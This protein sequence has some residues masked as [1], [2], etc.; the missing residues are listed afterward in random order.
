MVNAKLVYGIT[1]TLDDIREFKSEKIHDAL[2]EFIES[3]PNTEEE[4]KGDPYIDAIDDGDWELLGI[5]NKH[6]KL[7][8]QHNGACCNIGGNSG[9]DEKYFVGWESNAEIP[10]LAGSHVIEMITTA[11]KRK[12]NNFVKNHF[13]D[14]SPEFR[15]MVSDCMH[16]T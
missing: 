12:V 6:S 3:Y 4:S 5:L 8:F 16:C 14:K 13:P 9:D 2:I 15:M 7:T 1:L 10:S 11:E